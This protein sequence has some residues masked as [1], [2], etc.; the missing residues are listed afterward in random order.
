MVE[1]RIRVEAAE[2]AVET[3]IRVEAAVVVEARIQVEAAADAVEAG[4][5]RRHRLGEAVVDGHAV[6]AEDNTGH[7]E[8]ASW[9]A[10]EQQDHCKWEARVCM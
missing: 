1:R 8:H 2:V 10:R 4:D 6:A 3:C 9:A 5:D 7:R